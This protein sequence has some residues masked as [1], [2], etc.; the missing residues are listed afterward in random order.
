MYYAQFYS[1]DLLGHRSEGIG[2]RAVLIMDGRCKSMFDAW[3]TEHC[4]KYKY[5]GYS[6]HQG[7]SFTQ[8][9]ELRPFKEVKLDS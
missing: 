1:T 9:M 2:D 6:I 3:A 5:L 8:S 7:L 4:K